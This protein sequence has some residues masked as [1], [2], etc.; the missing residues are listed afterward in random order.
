MSDHVPAGYAAP[1]VSDRPSA[2]AWRMLALLALAELL[3]MSLWFTAS[4]AAPE[5]RALLSITTAQSS[6][7]TTA[8][9]LGF[10]AGTAVAAL[11][12]SADVMASRSWFVASALLGAAANVTVPL[13]ET[14]ELAL[15]G[16]F[17]TGFFL[18]GV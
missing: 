13:V 12:N 10:V 1:A 3:G 11:T 17:A 15:A 2:R 16:R 6:W 8:V 9:Q 4:A 7:L 5:L 14:F 18:A